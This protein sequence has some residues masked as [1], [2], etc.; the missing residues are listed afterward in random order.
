MQKMMAAATLRWEE[1]LT[2]GEEIRFGL[3]AMS[4]VKL[5]IGYANVLD[6]YVGGRSFCARCGGWLIGYP[7]RT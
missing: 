6:A 3:A 5:Y 2:L 4:E 7:N 1:L